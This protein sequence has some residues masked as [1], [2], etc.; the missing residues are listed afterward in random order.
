MVIIPN[1][2]TFVATPRTGSRAITEALKRVD[3]AEASRMHHVPWQDVPLTTR[4]IVTVHRDPYNQTLSWYYHAIVRQG[5]EP[6][7][8][9][10]LEFVKN[11]DIGWTFHDRL[12]IYAPIVD[13]VYWYEDGLETMMYD[14]G[15]ERFKVQHIG[16][17]NSD[18]SLLTKPVLA[19][20]KQRFPQDVQDFEQRE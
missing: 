3:G 13:M 7:E 9:S 8:A 4:P 12:Y 17:S 20:I 14:L 10:M 11:Y 1:R 19:A 5:E 16:R 15:L 18:K 6:T 2:F